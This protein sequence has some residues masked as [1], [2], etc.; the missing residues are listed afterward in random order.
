MPRAGRK[1]AEDQK[2]EEEVQAPKVEAQEPEQEP[3]APQSRARKTAVK[4]KVAAKK[5]QK[6]LAVSYEL[7]GDKV[8][9]LTKKANGNSYRLYQFTKS[10]NEQ[11]YKDLS[12]KQEKL[13]CPIKVI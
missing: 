13:G 7:K 1:K 8:V 3:E 10:K 9:Q 11:A 5:G 12:E 2:P 4:Q 6:V